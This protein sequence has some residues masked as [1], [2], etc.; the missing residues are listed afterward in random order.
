M[1]QDDQIRKVRA[2][3]AKAESTTHPE[4]ARTFTEKAIEL[5]EKWGIDEAMLQAMGEETEVDE[6]TTM[7]LEQKLSPYQAPREELLGSLARHYGAEWCYY[8]FPGKRVYTLVGF[9]RDLELIRM[10]WT[11]LLLQSAAELQAPETQARMDE[12]MRLAGITGLE[13]GAKVLQWRNSFQTGFNHGVA[14]QLQKAKK[15]SEG[16]VRQRALEAG[17]DTTGAIERAESVAIVLADRKLAVKEVFDK[18]I[19]MGLSKGKTSQ[20]TTASSSAYGSGKAA[21]LRASTSGARKELN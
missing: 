10:L 1:T 6:I 12:E 3:L 13:K 14:V 4:E 17:V 2:M 5:A 11:S 16:Y 15:E 9:S 20:R 8:Q 7:D 18:G 19:G 21:G